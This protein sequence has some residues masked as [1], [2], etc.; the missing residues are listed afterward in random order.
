M[1]HFICRCFRIVLCFA[2]E[3]SCSNCGDSNEGQSKKRVERRNGDSNDVKI[4]GGQ[5]NTNNE[6]KPK[7]SMAV[8]RALKKQGVVASSEVAVTKKQVELDKDYEMDNVFD[9]KA[10]ATQRSNF[11]L[12]SERNSEYE[13]SHLRE[14]CLGVHSNGLRAMSEAQFNLLPD[15]EAGQRKAKHVRK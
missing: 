3:Q 7:I 15:N 14:S 4:L 6:K 12:S 5:K 2:S 8:R 11:F 1:K 13:L 9:W 10:Q